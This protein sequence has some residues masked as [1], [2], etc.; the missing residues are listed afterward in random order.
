[1]G[2]RKST[3]IKSYTLKNGNNGACKSEYTPV[4]NKLKDKAASEVQGPFAL[5]SVEIYGRKQHA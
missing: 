1:M 4:R 5:D 3:R 2:S